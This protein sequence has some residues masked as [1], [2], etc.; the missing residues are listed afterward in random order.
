MWPPAACG[1]GVDVAENLGAVEAEDMDAAGRGYFR[2][3]V[4]HCR[5]PFSELPHELRL[6]HGEPV[7]HQLF[8]RARAPRGLHE[9]GLV[10]AVD[11]LD[12]RDGRAHPSSSV[13]ACARR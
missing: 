2:S 13:G 8:V 11:A 10:L 4:E 9:P 12:A 7:R 6:H 5:H 3:R 1:L